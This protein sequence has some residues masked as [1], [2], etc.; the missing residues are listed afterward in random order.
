MRSSFTLLLRGRV[1]LY[2]SRNVVSRGSRK[3]AERAGGSR[4]AGGVDPLPE[5]RSREPSDLPGDPL[6][7]ADERPQ[8]DV[9]HQMPVAFG[10]VGD[11]ALERQQVPLALGGEALE[12]GAPR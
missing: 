8:V 4:T 9:L 1:T 5:A 10:E 7:I 2:I 12:L 3:G 6:R 11:V